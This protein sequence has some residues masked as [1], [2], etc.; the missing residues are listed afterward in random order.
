M[1]F[2]NYFIGD[3]FGV[4]MAVYFWVFLRVR[5]VP[6]TIGFILIPV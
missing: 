5:S 3:V 2:G 6:K 4:V 1:L